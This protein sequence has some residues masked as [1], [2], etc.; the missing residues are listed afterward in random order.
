MRKNA[1]RAVFF[2]VALAVFLSITRVSF[3]APPSILSY[4]GRLTNASGDLLGGSSGTT[5]Y[6]RFAIW[7][8]L[9]GGTQLWPAG[10]PAIVG[11]PVQNGV[12]NGLI[13]DTTAGF[14]A[15]TLDFNT[16]SSIFL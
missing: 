11:L 14:D 4:Q 7:S 3:A 2:G 10:T 12:F 8:D 13:G 5:Y 9:T 16:D 6:F 15:L 1:L